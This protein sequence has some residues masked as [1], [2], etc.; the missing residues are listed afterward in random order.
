MHGNDILKT[1]HGGLSLRYRKAVQMIFQDPFGSLN[2][3]HTI[4]DHLEL[5]FKIHKIVAGKR[6][7]ERIYELLDTVGLTPPADVAMRYPYQFSGGQHQRAAI[8]RALAVNPEIILADEP[9]SMLMN[10]CRQEIIAPRNIGPDHWVRC[11]LYAPS[12]Q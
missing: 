12:K 2:P 1:E 10:I 6:I 11:H 8:A 4:H 9:I 5:P 3:V 7:R